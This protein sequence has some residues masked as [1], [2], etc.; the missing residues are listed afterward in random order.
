MEQINRGK[1]R[2][3]PMVFDDGCSERLFGEIKERHK[4][5]FFKDLQF[6]IH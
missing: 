5:C 1:G 2:M 3:Q 4:E 6:I